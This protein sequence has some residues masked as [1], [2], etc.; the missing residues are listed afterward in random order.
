MRVEASEQL[1]ALGLSVLWGTAAAL[2]YDLLRALR[3]RRKSS[4]LWTHALDGV[5]AVFLG[6]L[7]LNLALR[8]GQGELRLYFLLGGGAGFLLWF[9]LLSAPLR[10]VWDWWLDCLI[11][12]GRLLWRPVAF[13]LGLGQKIGVSIK[14]GFLFCRKYATIFLHRRL[15][16]VLRRRKEGGSVAKKQEK[17]T[18]RVSPVALIVIAALI[19]LVLVQIVQVYSKYRS[20][21]AEE[22]A[23]TERESTLQQ[24]ND[25]LRSDLSKKDDPAFWEQLAR[26]FANMVKQGERIFVDPNY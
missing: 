17:K 13:A 1:T 8:L 18:H 11:W 19:L 4:A 9:A 21:Q 20:M 6:L 24:E 16:P 5:Y 10:P 2:C 22:S 14:K 25:A 3:L 26:K 23:L 7:G 15:I 12:F